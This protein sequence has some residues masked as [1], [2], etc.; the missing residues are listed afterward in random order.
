MLERYIWHVLISHVCS[1]LGE[2]VQRLLVKAL[3]VAFLHR[4]AGQYGCNAFRDRM[5]GVLD[6]L[7][8]RVEIGF[9]D[10][11]A[12][13]NEENTVNINFPG[14]DLLEHLQNQG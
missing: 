13:T 6:S 4:N 12:V 11:V 3:D 14:L 5:D 8:I 2:K 1:D 10:Q 7:R 9:S